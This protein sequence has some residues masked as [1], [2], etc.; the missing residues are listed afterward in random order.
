[1]EDVFVLYEDHFFICYVRGLAPGR[2]FGRDF[3]R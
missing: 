3:G 2:C 1:M